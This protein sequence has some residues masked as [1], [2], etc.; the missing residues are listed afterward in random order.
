MLT[1]EQQAML[2][3]CGAVADVTD[4]LLRSLY[5]SGN[6]QE[7]FEAIDFYVNEVGN[8]NR[9]RKRT[10]LFQQIATFSLNYRLPVQFRSVANY[11]RWH[12]QYNTRHQVSIS[13]TIID[14]CATGADGLR[15]AEESLVMA[16]EQF[17]HENNLE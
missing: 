2:R 8:V 15:R 3:N 13:D 14:A 7:M 12:D 10:N 17:K 9:E 5:Q 16:I 6:Y 1:E 4:R 11:N